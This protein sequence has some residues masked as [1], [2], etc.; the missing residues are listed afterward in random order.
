MMRKAPQL[1]VLLVG[2]ILLAASYV[3][4]VHFERYEFAF[5]LPLCIYSA[6]IIA[7]A[8][9]LL[10]ADKRIVAPWSKFAI[11]WT[12]LCALLVYFSPTNGSA[13]FRIDKNTVSMALGVIFVAVSLAIIIK[14]SFFFRQGGRHSV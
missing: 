10:I 7:V 12:A 11:P 8:L 2:L 14:R 13:L 5:A 6:A 9:M 1:T 4:L 3:M